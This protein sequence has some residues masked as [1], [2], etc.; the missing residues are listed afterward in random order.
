MLMSECSE[1]TI[2]GMIS[3]V[4]KVVTRNGRSAGQQMAIITLEDLDG[5]IDGT[6]FA[7]SYAQVCAKYPQAVAAESIVFVR[8]KIDKK[9]ETPSILVNEVIPI[10]DALPRLTTAVVLK[11]DRTRHSPDVVKQLQPVLRQ[12]K[13][14]LPVFM[15]VQY[16]GSSTVTMKLGSE[17]FVRLG[18][19]LVSELDHVLGSGSVQLVGAGTRRVK[20]IQ[21]QQLF[22][23]ETAESEAAI[24]PASEE[25]AMDAEME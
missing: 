8:G 16:N 10:A 4:K 14:N 20:R 19:A 17:M 2:G 25:V 1:V 21:Q 12:N 7:E 22:K 3:K 15:E 6:L 9:R 18:D 13:G 24:A 23:E 5:Q 11:L